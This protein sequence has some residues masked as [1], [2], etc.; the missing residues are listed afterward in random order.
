MSE[1]H[2]HITRALVEC[3]LRIVERF[4]CQHID[5]CRAGGIHRRAQARK[6]ICRRGCI[7][8]LL[9]RRVAGVDP[10]AGSYGLAKK[11]LRDATEAAALE[12]APDIRVNAVAPGYSLPPPGVDPEKM[13]PLLEGVPMRQ[14]SSPEEIAAA[15]VF[16]ARSPTVTGHVLFVDGGLHLAHGGPAEVP[17]ADYGNRGAAATG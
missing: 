10:A 5:L 12:W 16:L 13:L 4:R 1:S 8:N 11:A 6:W 2:S 17:R 9:D 7:V 15:C 3:R 14:P